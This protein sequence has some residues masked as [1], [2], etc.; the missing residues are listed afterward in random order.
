MRWLRWFL[1]A[2]VAAV[3]VMAGAFWRDWA[4]RAPEGAPMVE[5][6]IP[7]GASLPAAGRILEAAGLVEDGERFALSARLMGGGR[8]LKA[9]DYA[10]PRGAGGRQILDILAS[11]R[12]IQRFITIPEGMPSVLVAERLRAV[13]GLTGEVAVPEEGSVL[14][15]TYAWEGGEPRAAVL[16]RMQAAMTKALA[17]EWPRRSARAWPRTPAEAVNLAAII[18]KETAKPAERRRIAGVYTNRLRAG[19]KLDADP[20]VIYPITRGRPLGR[21][22]RQSELRADT[23]WNTYVRP[24]LPKTPIANP[25]RES[26]R[27]ALD[28]EPHDFLFFVADGTGGHVFARTYDEHRANVEKWFAIRRARGEM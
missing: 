13:E 27:A 15:D 3:L 20:T 16:A 22:I 17:E 23:G 4:K 26:I 25:G 8:T 9:G 19:M 5:V 6:S 14:P 18:E 12:T 2:L 21:R 10:V 1:L 24:G 7:R 11:G 28:P